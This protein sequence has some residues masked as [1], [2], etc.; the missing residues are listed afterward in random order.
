MSEY[1]TDTVLWAE[2]QAALLRRR[3]A[4]EAVNEE[5][6]WENIIEEI[7][8]LAGSR[9]H[10]LASHIRR[11]LEHQIKLAVSPAPRPR[12]AWLRSIIQ[13]QAAVD[14]L[15]EEN[16]S[17]RREV[18]AIIERMLPKARKIALKTLETYGEQPTVD[19]DTLTF[20]AQQVLGDAP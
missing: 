5:P 14:Q 15:L 19:P 13:A 20:T 6:D 3:L 8:D 12:D 2:H 9:R 16:P 11:I 17:L 1:E 7:E 18:P 10:A 4:G